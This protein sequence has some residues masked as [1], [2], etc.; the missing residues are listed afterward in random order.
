MYAQATLAQIA[1]ALVEGDLSPADAVALLEARAARKPEG[2]YAQ[3]R[4]LN[5]A[6]QIAETGGLDSARA[7]AESKRPQ[8]KAAKAPKTTKARKSRKPAAKAAAQPN[9]ATLASALAD[10][11]IEVDPA[12]VAAIAAFVRIK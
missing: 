9:I 6:A 4:A 3:R 7:F 5:A 1:E 11:G 12:Q 8:A 10:A 2:S